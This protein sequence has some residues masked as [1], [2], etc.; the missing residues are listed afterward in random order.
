MED[1]LDK[2]FNLSEFKKKLEKKDLSSII[3]SHR[4]LSEDE[5]KKQIENY[6]SYIHNLIST[7]YNTPKKRIIFNLAQDFL[8][9]SVKSRNLSL[10]ECKFK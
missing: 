4:N 8:A 5:K 10:E 6:K 1:K 3:P 7:K 9:K 2:F